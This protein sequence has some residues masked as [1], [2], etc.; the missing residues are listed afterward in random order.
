M[1]EQ[2]RAV[3]DF[4]D[5]LLR[6]ASCRREFLWSA[7]DQLFA[8]RMK[9]LVGPKHCPMCREQRRQFFRQRPSTGR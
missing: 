7:G 6:C 5:R 3:S 1:T 8:W 9:F 2:Q 4:Q